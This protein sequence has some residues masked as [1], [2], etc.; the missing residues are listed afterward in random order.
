MLKKC[1]ASLFLLA[2]L[3]MSF[4]KTVIVVDFYANQSYIAKNLCENRDK[5][6]L[7]CCGRCL[8]RKRLA[9]QD[10]QD[11]NNPDRKDDRSSEVLYFAEDVFQIPDCSQGC[12]SIT[13]GQFQ[14]SPLKDRAVAFFHPPGQA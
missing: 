13:Y 5:P 1:T 6:M 10:K 11:Q 7:H 9:N 12:E 4:S 14:A 3:V 2:F 8:L